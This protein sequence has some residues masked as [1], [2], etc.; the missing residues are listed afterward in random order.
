MTTD[1]FE[2]G[3]LQRRIGKD[4]KMTGKSYSQ[5]GEDIEI[6][7]QFP[8]GYVGHVL[9]IGSWH[10]TQL[11][12]SRLFIEAGWSATLVEF[13][14]KPVHE[15]LKEYGQRSDIRIIPAAITADEQPLLEFLISEDALSTNDGESAD[16]WAKVANFYGHMLV[17]TLSVRRLIDQCF[18]SSR[19]N[20]ASVDTEGNSVPIAVAIMETDWRPEVLCVE[21]DNQLAYLQT[22]AQRFGYKTVHTN[23]TN[24]ILSR[25]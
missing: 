16:K 19:F 13:S 11:S 23:S 24:C 5:F 9:E 4:G 3:L 1:A 10:P 7:K 22:Q 18:G 15:L 6:A 2:S 14:P 17:P 12:N 8:E 25:I 21:Y 20:V